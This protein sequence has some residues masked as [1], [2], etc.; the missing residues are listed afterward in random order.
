M[1]TAS[2][3]HWAAHHQPRAALYA[4]GGFRRAPCH[5]VPA[6]VHP[7]RQPSGISE[8]QGRPRCLNKCL[9]RPWARGSA[10]RRLR[11]QAARGQWGRGRCYS[12]QPPRSISCCPASC[13]SHITALAYGICRS[14]ARHAVEKH[15]RSRLTSSSKRLCDFNPIF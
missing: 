11:G 6:I 13:I 1:G 10:G 4:G 12:T 2:A 15:A 5:A 14:R 9:R 3:P 7:A 8:R